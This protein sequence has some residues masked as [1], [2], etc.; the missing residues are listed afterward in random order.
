MEYQAADIIDTV[1]KATS[2]KPCLMDKAWKYKL[3]AYLNQTGNKRE[4][5]CFR[6]GRDGSESFNQSTNYF[7]NFK[8]DKI[9]QVVKIKIIIQA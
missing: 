1:V 7:Y 4:D 2:S 6:Q 5:Q 8:S 3:S 9:Q